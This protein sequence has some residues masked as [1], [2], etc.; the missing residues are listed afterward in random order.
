MESSDKTYTG[1]ITAVPVGD[2][3]NHSSSDDSE[4]DQEQYSEDEGDDANNQLFEFVKAEPPTN[5]ND[6]YST[7]PPKIKISQ[8]VVRFLTV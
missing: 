6:P 8:I 4:Y 1:Q 2:E 5:Y 3:A 7:L